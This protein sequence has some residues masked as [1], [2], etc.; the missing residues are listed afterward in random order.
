[1]TASRPLHVVVMGVTAAGKSTVGLALARA[2][3]AEFID[4]DT[5]HPPAN[6]AKMAAGIPL[7]DEDRRPWLRS[8]AALMA[9]RDARGV[10]TVVACSALRRSYRDILRAA[11]PDGTTFF[12]HLD[13]A[14]DILADRMRDRSHFMP[15]S[16]LESQFDTLER[17]GPDEA[18]VTV[19]VSGPIDAVVAGARASITSRYGV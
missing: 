12:V 13:A 19:D 15:P 1:M 9:D 6:V 7:T 17:L 5:V 16:L 3:G 2:L 10:A 11:V 18:G 8:L 14:P 4:G